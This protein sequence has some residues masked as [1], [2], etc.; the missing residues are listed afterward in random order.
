MVEQHR[1]AQ[2]EK[3][4]LQAKFEEERAHA[5]QE[6]EQFLTEQL[7][8]QRSSRQSTSLCDRIRAKGRRPSGASSSVARRSYPVATT[9]NSRLRAL[10]SA[11]HSTQMYEIKEKQ[12]LEAQLKE[13]RPSPWNVNN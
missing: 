1:V 4:D 8:S 5:K 9:K 2:K 12:L 6:K 10:N 11:Q 3:E 13:S 7:G